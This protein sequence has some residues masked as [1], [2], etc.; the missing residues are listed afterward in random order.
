[1]TTPPRPIDR[2][3]ILA[4][5]M[6]GMASAADGG[7][8]RGADALGEWLGEGGLPAS[9]DVDDLRPMD[10]EVG[11][12]FFLDDPLDARLELLALLAVPARNGAILRTREGGPL[13]LAARRLG[14]ASETTQ[15]VVLG[16]PERAAER[17]ERLRATPAPR[18]APRRSDVVALR[19]W[20]RNVA[21]TA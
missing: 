7:P 3:T 6:L 13:A 15:A 5:L 19:R 14:C 2:A 17:F 10:V 12:G 4:E 1:M 9:V 18:R 16:H 20:P 11:L 8:S 21:T